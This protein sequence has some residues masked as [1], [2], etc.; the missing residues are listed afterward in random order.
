LPHTDVVVPQHPLKLVEQRPAPGRQ[1]QG[2]Y[3]LLPRLRIP[4]VQRPLQYFTALR[5]GCRQT[6]SRQSRCHRDN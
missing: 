3:R 1:A 6:A 5:V 4:G 2:D